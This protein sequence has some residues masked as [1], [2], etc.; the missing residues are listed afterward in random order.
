M[1]ATHTELYFHALFAVKDRK[2][3]IRKGMKVPLYTYI[4]S[5]FKMEGQH[6]IAINGTADHVHLLFRISASKSIADL[7][8]DV[9]ALSSRYINQNGL[10][11][12]PF[13]WEHGYGA[14]SCAHGQVPRIRQMIERQELYHE[15]KTFYDEYTELMGELNIDFSRSS[16][17]NWF[18][19]MRS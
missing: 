8:R 17:L 5:V 3:L 9:K 2:K 6:L 15:H 16:K 11:S 10:S 12:K 13:Y 18:D 4:K 1:A 19:V 7:M 14:F